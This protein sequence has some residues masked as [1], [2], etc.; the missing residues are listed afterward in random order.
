MLRRAAT[1]MREKKSNDL[2]VLARAALEGA[3]RDDHD[4]ISLLPPA[5]NRAT[6]QNIGRDHGQHVHA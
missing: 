2:F 4:L 3:I 5:K 6:A 1:A